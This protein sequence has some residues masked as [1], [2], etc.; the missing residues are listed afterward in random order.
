MATVRQIFQFHNILAIQFAEEKRL[1]LS[2]KYN[3]LKQN[4]TFKNKNKAAKPVHTIPFG[5]YQSNTATIPSHYETIRAYVYVT[6]TAAQCHTMQDICMENRLDS[7]R[8]IA[9]V[10]MATIK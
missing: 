7:F 5:S 1:K 6:A 9:P 10:S 2:P 4:M 8:S 3:I